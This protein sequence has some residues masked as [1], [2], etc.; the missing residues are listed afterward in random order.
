MLRS[1][2]ARCSRCAPTTHRADGRR[3]SISYSS[4]TPREPCSPPGRTIG[5]LRVQ[6]A[7]YPEGPEVCQAIIVHPPGGIVG[8]D[9]LAIGDRRR[10]ARAR[11]AHDA[12]R[13]EVVPLPGRARSRSRRCASA[14]GRSSNGCRRRRSCSTARAHRSR[15]ASSSRPQCAVH[16]LGRHVPRAHGVGRALHERKAAPVARALSRGRARVL[17]ARGARRRLAAR[18]NPVQSSSGAPVFGT[19]IAAGATIDRTTLLASCRAVALRHGRRRA[20]APAGRVRRALSRR[21]GERGA[22]VFCYSVASAATGARGPRRRA[23]PH[24]EHLNASAET[25]WNS[26]RERR[27]S[28]CSSPRRSLAER[29]LARGVK[30]NYPGSRRL[31]LRGDHGRRARR[32]HRRRAHEPRR[33]AAHARTR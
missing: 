4:A 30:L 33:D 22:H 31:H 29:R 28:C 15:F 11:A 3:A 19:L 32:P 27:T 2:L 6:K 18:S 12:R 20:H 9:S 17:R 8:G 7:L 25:R 13:G 14:P 1:P 26:R 16:R 10:S 5:P 21:L 24:L 23:A